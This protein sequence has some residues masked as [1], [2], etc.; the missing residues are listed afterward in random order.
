MKNN[1]IK[2][3]FIILLFSS[4]IPVRITTMNHPGLTTY[5]TN[6][7][8]FD[9]TNI[10]LYLRYRRYNCDDSYI[11]QNPLGLDSRYSRYWTSIEFYNS[12]YGGDCINYQVPTYN[13]RVF[14]TKQ[15]KRRRTNKLRRN[16]NTNTPKIPNIVRPRVQNTR[17]PLRNTLRVNSTPKP[18][19]RSIKNN[20]QKKNN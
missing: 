15:Y 3:I 20:N 8:M 19:T 6:S 12:L 13:E 4:C 7:T 18:N 14:T 2:L 10:P 11:I 16:I 1:T 17:P 9:G 5:R